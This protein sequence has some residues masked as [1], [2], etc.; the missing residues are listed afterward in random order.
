M[1]A[2][3]LVNGLGELGEGTNN[4][5]RLKALL[6]VLELLRLPLTPAVVLRVLDKANVFTLGDGEDVELIVED[7]TVG[8]GAEREDETLVEA[9]L[10]ELVGVCAVP[11]VHVLRV[12]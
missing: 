11:V 10:D 6:H 4:V 12:S 5:Y 7:E 3:H 8:V 9:G 2:T 1:H